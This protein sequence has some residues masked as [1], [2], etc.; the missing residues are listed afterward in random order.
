MA[1]PPLTQPSYDGGHVG[2]VA[3]REKNVDDI[4]SDLLTDDDTDYTDNRV[5]PDVPPPPSPVAQT[6]KPASSPKSSALERPPA[7][8]KTKPK[9][10]IGDEESPFGVPRKYL[11]TLGVLVVLFALVM[12]WTSS[13]GRPSPQALAKKILGSNDTAEKINALADLGTRSEPEV[14]ELLRDIVKQSKD[15]DVV[16]RGLSFLCGLRDGETMSLAL[17]ALDDPSEKVRQ[18][19]IEAV[20]KSKGVPLEELNLRPQDEPSVRG[21]IIAKLRQEYESRP[22]SNLPSALK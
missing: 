16:S 20:A 9:P 18:A 1:F 11:I 8:G 21:P 12:W 17:A 15:P 5:V 4:A 3:G 7:P 14:R 19:A 22:R 10:G 2:V 6:K 13:P